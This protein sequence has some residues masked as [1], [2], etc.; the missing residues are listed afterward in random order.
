MISYGNISSLIIQRNGQKYTIIFLALSGRNGVRSTVL[1]IWYRRRV[2]CMW[3]SV[4]G[5][6]LEN[7]MWWVLAWICDYRSMSELAQSAMAVGV[8]SLQ[9]QP[10]GVAV[11][12]CRRIKRNGGPGHPLVDQLCCRS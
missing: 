11:C 5:D 3:R 10:A 7:S 1:G 8:L 4:L 6:D 2:F 9:D 12:F